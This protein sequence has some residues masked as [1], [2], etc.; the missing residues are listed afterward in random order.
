MDTFLPLYRGGVVGTVIEPVSYVNTNGSVD[1]VVGE[2][3]SAL[4]LE[5]LGSTWRGAATL[6]FDSELPFIPGA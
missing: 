6:I 3:A 2:P 4:M 5:H 1:F